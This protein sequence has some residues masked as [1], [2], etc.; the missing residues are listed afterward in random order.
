MFEIHDLTTDERF[1]S[2]HAGNAAAFM[3]SRLRDY[4][5]HDIVISRKA[6]D[7]GRV[8]NDECGNPRGGDFVAAIRGGAS[9]TVR[10]GSHG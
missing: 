7:D 1:Y 2:D 8:H 6:G 10:K 3:E 4:P 5:T 9:G